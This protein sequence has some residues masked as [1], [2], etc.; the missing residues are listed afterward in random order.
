M[1]ATCREFDELYNH[2]INDA[3]END[4]VDMTM[5]QYEEIKHRPFKYLKVWQ[6]FK[7]TSW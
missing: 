4:L 6:K 1:R 5:Y 7:E 3:D 2:V